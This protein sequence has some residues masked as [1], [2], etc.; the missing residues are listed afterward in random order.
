MDI[1]LTWTGPQELGWPS[2]DHEHE[3]NVRM[4]EQRWNEP[5][6]QNVLDN[7]AKPLN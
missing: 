3:F 1:S 7:I 2:Y 5:E 6:R 4:A